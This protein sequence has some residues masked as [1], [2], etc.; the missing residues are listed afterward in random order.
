MNVVF[1]LDGTICFDGQ[2]IDRRI[3]DFLEQEIVR[4]PSHQLVFASARPVRDIL[5]VLPMALRDCY[6]IGGNGAMCYFQQE[7]VWT[8]P[9]EPGD[10]PKIIEYIL[11][12]KLDYM[13]DESWNYSFKGASLHH[14]KPKVDILK[15]A[16]NIEITEVRDP[17]K[18]LLS[19]Y[20]DQAQVMAD[21]KELAV[22]FIP[23]PQEECLDLTKRGVNKATAL[24][25]IMP[26]EAYVAFGNDVNDLELLQGASHSVCVG[27]NQTVAQVAHQVIAEN[28]LS[29]IHAISE[30]VL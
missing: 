8:N 20:Q 16:Q 6:L 3:T 1:D 13:I 2:H 17:L 14:L 27:N 28:A 7:A 24:A 12:H 23:Y 22:N 26:Q 19:N 18:I 30:S 9:L 29:I 25:A 10:V 5:P 21:L 11:E 4:Q 15:T